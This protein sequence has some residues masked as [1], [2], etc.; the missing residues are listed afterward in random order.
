[1]S[2]TQS[3][4][5]SAINSANSNAPLINTDSSFPPISF[6]FPFD[7]AVDTSSA[8]S[9]DE[10]LMLILN[11]ALYVIDGGRDLHNN[12]NTNRYPRQ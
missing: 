4:C 2:S 9:E 5:N 6:P 10:R 1:M 12:Q 8:T 7:F 3:T 11:E